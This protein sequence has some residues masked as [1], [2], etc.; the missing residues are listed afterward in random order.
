MVNANNPDG[1]SSDTT[2]LRSKDGEKTDTMSKRTLK[3]TISP[4]VY[5]FVFSNSTSLFWR[6]G[7]GCKV[8][9]VPRPFRQTNIQDWWRQMHQTKKC[10]INL[11]LETKK[12]L[13]NIAELISYPDS[14]MFALLK[15]WVGSA[16]TIVSEAI[17]NVNNSLPL[18]DIIL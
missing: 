15:N 17:Q 8:P 4:L 1:Y 18:L 16:C 11:I 5:I 3:I 6:V 14:P 9:L 7:R 12:K 10:I 13:I 2:N